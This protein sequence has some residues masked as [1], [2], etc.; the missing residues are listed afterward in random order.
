MD[1]G[2]EIERRGDG[3]SETPIEFWETVLF[4]ACSDYTKSTDTRSRFLSLCFKVFKVS[5][6][7]T[8]CR[9]GALLRPMWA[10]S[11][12]CRHVLEQAHGKGKLF[13][14]MLG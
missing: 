5:G 13:Y 11:V 3:E 14:H 10:L 7:H 2:E 8:G 12:Q 4:L 1:P 9:Q 6:S